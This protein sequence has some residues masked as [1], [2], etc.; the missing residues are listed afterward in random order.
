MAQIFFG[1]GGGVVHGAVGAQAIRGGGFKRSYPVRLSM[2]VRSCESIR[3]C[4]DESHG[5]PKI[6]GNGNPL[7]T[8]IL[9]TP[10]FHVPFPDCNSSFTYSSQLSGVWERDD[11]LFSLVG[12][13]Y[14]RS[15]R[16]LQSSA[17]ITVQ[18]Q[19]MSISAWMGIGNSI[20][21]GP[22]A[23]RVV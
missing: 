21:Q 12:S 20:I 1:V 18:G 9:C 4:S 23:C 13:G 8:F 22:V 10:D 11:K 6:M 19:P 5:I 17:L 3:M 2:A 14:R 16:Q 15:P 7:F